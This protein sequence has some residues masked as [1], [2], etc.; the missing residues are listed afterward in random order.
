MVETVR[1]VSY[2]LH[3]PSAEYIDTDLTVTAIYRPVEIT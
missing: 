1:H 3:I 2:I